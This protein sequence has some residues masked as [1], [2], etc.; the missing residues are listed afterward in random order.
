MDVRD[1]IDSGILEAY[2]LGGLSDQ[3]IREVECMSHIY[4]EIGQALVQL[5]SKFETAALNQA[6]APPE[7]LKTKVM[8]AIRNAPQEIV[9]TDT[10]VADS[11]KVIPIERKPTGPILKIALAASIVGIISLVY[12]LT[13]NK[14][15]INSLADQRDGMIQEN[16]QLVA[17]IENLQSA[18]D[19]QEQ[20]NLF[21]A[22][23][24]THLVQLG[25][26]DISPDSKVRVFWNP[27]ME[28]VGL[29]ID[30]LP[31]PAEGKQYQL[32]AIVD[33]TPTDMGVFDLPGEHIEMIEFAEEAPQAFAIT[34]EKE[35][36][37]P[38]PDLSA[39]YVIGN[40]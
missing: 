8:D 7:R 35:G 37:S 40:V 34:L 27:A 14:E 18:K 25:G 9:T 6:I 15:E 19:A 16:Q 31:D 10:G 38:T 33:G 17:E 1:Y 2:V 21:L 13:T 32:W 26:T 22:D 12:L 5:Q 4:E 28:K 3:E 24:S 23:N 20:L 29:K 11:T 39:L 30:Q 36:G